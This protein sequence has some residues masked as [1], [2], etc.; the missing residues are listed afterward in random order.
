MKSIINNTTIDSILEKKNHYMDSEEV[1]EVVL[2][3]RRP[4]DPFLRLFTDEELNNKP[5][6]YF[7]QTQEPD[8]CFLHVKNGKK[9][10]SQFSF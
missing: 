1:E 7:K 5:G 4:T 9:H 8:E 3:A 10:I 6:Q 2:D